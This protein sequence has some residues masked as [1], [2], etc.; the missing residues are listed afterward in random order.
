MTSFTC[1]LQGVHPSLEADT[2]CPSLQKVQVA[3]PRGEYDPCEQARQEDDDVAPVPERY[4]PASHRVQ[5]S[6]PPVEYFP[7]G[8]EEQLEEPL[9]E[10]SPVGQLVQ[11]VAPTRLENFPTAQA[12]QDELP[13]SEKS[14]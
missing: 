2:I 14:P 3:D 11:Y 7:S 5:S 13:G 1:R 6:P 10:V 4:F 8:Q 9:T 12:A